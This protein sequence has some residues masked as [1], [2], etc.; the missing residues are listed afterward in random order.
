MKQLG[1]M[2]T[3]Q[4]AANVNP[5]GAGNRPGPTASAVSLVDTQRVAAWL[6]KHT[7]A[8]MDKA[9]V[10]RASQHGVGLRVKYEMRF[11]TGP[12][13]ER[14]PS[15][16]VAV[17]CD[18]SGGDVGAALADLRNFMAPAPPRE[19]EGWIAELSVISARRAGDEFSE[20]LRLTA[21]AMRL[22]RY[23]ADVARH[24]L[25]SQTYKFFPTWDELEKR[26][27]AIAGPRRHMIAALERGPEPP[28]PLRRPATDE[29]KARIKA[30][31]D[32]LFPMR[33][34][35]MRDAAVAEMTKGNCMGGAA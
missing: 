35:E 16:D 12:N 11:P 26:C 7:P 33:S 30:L 13:G 5:Q 9:A 29:E 25:L 32:E 14:L 2:L 17:G 15:Y 20:G 24:V 3:G 22:A 4:I 6:A 21:Y 27:E 23:P 31:V 1:S 34:Q 10:S 28:E 18:I 19:I 8:D